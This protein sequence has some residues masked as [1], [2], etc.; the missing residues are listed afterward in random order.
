MNIPNIHL[1]NDFKQEFASVNPGMNANDY[2]IEYLIYWNARINIINAGHINGIND[3]LS[4]IVASL[5][6]QLRRIVQLEDK[7]KQI[8]KN[9]SALFKD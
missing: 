5:N 9:N 6:E 1:F 7:M 2:P 3:R 8:A 4:T